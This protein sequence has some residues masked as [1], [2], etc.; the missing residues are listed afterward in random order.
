MN[1]KGALQTSTRNVEEYVLNTNK[2]QD[3]IEHLGGEGTLRQAEEAFAKMRD[4]EYGMIEAD[5]L[6][7]FIRVK[8]EAEGK[9]FDKWAKQGHG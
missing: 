9:D 2:F 4:I 1:W 7:D 3:A 5:A 6:E 8:M